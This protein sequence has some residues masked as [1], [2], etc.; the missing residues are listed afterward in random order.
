MTDGAKANLPTTGKIGRGSSL[1]STGTKKTCSD[2]TNPETYYQVSS[3]KQVSLTA[4]LTA[5]NKDIVIYLGYTGSVSTSSSSLLTNYLTLT[6]DGTQKTIANSKNLWTAGFGQTKQNGRTGYMF[7]ILGEYELTAG[8]H[9][10]VVSIK[11][12][13]FN[14]GTLCI[15][16]HVEPTA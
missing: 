11:S 15:F 12:N 6:I 8:S 13:T 5:G 3:G 16:D 7:N 1:S 4:D 9:T 10:V 14:I 2:F